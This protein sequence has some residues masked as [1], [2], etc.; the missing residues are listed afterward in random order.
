MDG[1]GYAS[2]Y[3]FAGGASLAISGT[4]SSAVTA[5]DI[6]AG[7]KTLI[8]TL[9]GDTY[10]SGTTSII[11]VSSVLGTTGTTT[12]FTLTLPSTV[13]NDIMLMEYT[14]RS[15]IQGDIYG[16]VSTGWSTA[17][18]QLFSGLSTFSGRTLWKRATGDHFGE[19]V[20]VSS[21]INSC[22][23]VCTVY[24][25]AH[26]SDPF[27]SALIVGEQNTVGN[28]DQAGITVVY[29]N[30]MVCLVV[31][32]SPDFAISAQSSI[33]VGDLTERAERL[34]TGG[35]DA[36]I[37]HASLEFASTGATSTF[38]WAQTNASSGSWGYALL[39]GSLFAYQ[40]GPFI[41][42]VSSATN[43]TSTWNTVR[44][45]IPLSTVVRTS[46]TV[47]TVT[48]PALSSYANTSTE[49]LTVTAPAAILTGAT[50]IVGS[51]TFDIDTA[52]VGITF[53]VLA[54]G[55]ASF[56]S[57][58]LSTASVSPGSNKLILAIIGVAWDVYD[59]DQLTVTGN[60]L[61]WDEVREEAVN[62]NGANRGLYV[63]RAMAASPS[64]GAVTF[65]DVAVNDAS[66]GAYVI[67]E[68]S[69]VV[70][71]NNGADAIS[72]VVG[73]NVDSAA[74]EVGLTITGTPAGSDVTFGVGAVGDGPTLSSDALWAAIQTAASADFSIT[75]DYDSG[76]DQ[77]PTWTWTAARQ[78]G[79]IG[80]ILEAA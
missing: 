35:T 79:A 55:G 26:S 67:L 58:A 5:S 53:N 15:T 48:L 37:S 12:S 50:P 33:A 34:S 74:T 71:G 1:L 63:F 73:N 22:A 52:P 21:L 2:F 8:A 14:H 19:T 46:D 60:G 49:T 75:V 29:P 51:P 18:V 42:G 6:V 57:Q 76:Q 66:T 44:A 10:V 61:T 27:G 80:F 7:G 69:G 56:A 41:N 31:A 30:S 13:A 24:R 20:S 3:P 4:V 28:E 9:T 70:T 78:G 38:S 72:N 32:N 39:P 54:S 65:N 36:S 23:G 16:S 45:N 40:R 77:T 47:A 43:E 25:N 64:A 11:F 59:V 17:H 68:V 62:Q